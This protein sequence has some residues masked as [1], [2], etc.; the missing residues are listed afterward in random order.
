[1]SN[2]LA[3]RVS[4]SK[5]FMDKFYAVFGQDIENKVSTFNE[6][7][8]KYGNR[9]SVPFYDFDVSAGNISMFSDESEHSTFGI[10]VPGFEDCSLA[11]PVFGHSMYPTFENGC[12]LICKKIKDIS[13]LQY[14]ET[15]L[16]VTKEQR[17]VKRLLK[18][19]KEHKLLC[20]SDNGEATKTGNRKYEDFELEKKKIL[21]LFI[22]KGSIR[23]S[24]I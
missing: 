17:F 19:T 1:V 5:N 4:A 2:Y 23:R 20:V 16:V 3:G 22:V 11:L 13:V 12:I 14:G 21:H 10:T 8:S 24:Q 15:Y 18:S 7:A 9:K 6:P